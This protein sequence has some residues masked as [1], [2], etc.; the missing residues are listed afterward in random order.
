MAGLCLHYSDRVT[1]HTPYDAVTDLF[2]DSGFQ[3]GDSSVAALY[4]LTNQLVVTESAWPAVSTDC[5]VTVPLTGTT[6]SSRRKFPCAYCG[7]EFISRADHERH[8]N[9]HLGI[10]PFKCRL[11]DRTFV[12]K[13]NGAMHV[14]NVHNKKEN[15]ELYIERAVAYATGDKSLEIRHGGASIDNPLLLTSVEA[16]PTPADH[17]PSVR[18]ER[19]GGTVD[20]SAMR[21]DPEREKFPVHSEASESHV[22]SQ[23]QIRPEETRC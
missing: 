16:R 13:F 17:P 23:F 19:S 9:I 12:R 7:N 21:V 6:I 22:G 3:N 8:T 4:K 10:R 1:V 14:R 2:S 18:G 5:S 20:Q 15:A 11:C